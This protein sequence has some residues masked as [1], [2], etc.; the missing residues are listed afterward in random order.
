MVD[1]S[2]QREVDKLVDGVLSGRVNRRELL[3]RAAALGIAVPGV[4]LA[5]ATPDAVAARHDG[6]RPGRHPQAG[7]LSP[8]HH[9]R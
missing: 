4:L 6:A 8:G 2:L 5:R 3:Q 9:R 1:K 7:W